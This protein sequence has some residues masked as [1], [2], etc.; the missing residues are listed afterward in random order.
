MAHGSIGTLPVEYD[1]KFMQAMLAIA[2]MVAPTYTQFDLG[3]VPAA[4]TLCW[5]ELASAAEIIN[6]DSNQS[7]VLATT[8]ELSP[9]PSVGSPVDVNFVLNNFEI[10]E[11]ELLELQ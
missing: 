2:P 6:L 8:G 9:T 3:M 5:S 1:T 4:M 7:C 10:L 11:D